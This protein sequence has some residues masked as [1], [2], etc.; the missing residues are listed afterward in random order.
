LSSVDFP[1]PVAT[2]DGDE[3]AMRDRQAGLLHRRI[4]PRVG[5]PKGHRC[6]VKRDRMLA[7][8]YP[9]RVPSKIWMMP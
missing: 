8:P 2:Y 6:V 3:F 4:D 5:Q 9:P 7:D 1:H